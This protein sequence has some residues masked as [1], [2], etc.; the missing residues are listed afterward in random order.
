MN[1]RRRSAHD[2]IPKKRRKVFFKIVTENKHGDADNKPLGE[3]IVMELYDDIVPKTA[4][5]FF[6]LCTHQNGFGYRGNK[7]HRVIPQF[8]IQGGDIVNGDGT[9]SISIYDELECTF[10]FFNVIP[11]PAPC[12][13]PTFE[14][15]NFKLKH[16]GPGILSMANSDKVDTNGSQ[17]FITTV[18]TPWL[19]GKNVVFGRVIEGWAYSRQKAMF[20]FPVFRPQYP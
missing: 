18:K 13:G 3:P 7:F 11:P 6:E 20:R 15:E 16:T 2:P 12:L 5:N 10:Y 14:D 9:G 4:R 17:F 1:E 19:D 8:M